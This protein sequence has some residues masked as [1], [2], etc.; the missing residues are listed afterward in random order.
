[1]WNMVLKLTAVH[2]KSTRLLGNVILNLPLFI[3]L[4]KLEIVVN[5]LFERSY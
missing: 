4:N 5:L 3:V 2:V 1:M